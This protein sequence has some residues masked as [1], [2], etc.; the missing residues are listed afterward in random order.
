MPSL[1][2]HPND[3][4]FLDVEWDKNIARGSDEMRVIDDG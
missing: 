3:H 2:L 1:F 4:L